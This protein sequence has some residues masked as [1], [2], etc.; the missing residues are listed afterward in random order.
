MAAL[1]QVGFQCAMPGGS[2]FL[3][4]PAPT[5]AGDRAFATAE[6][7]SQFLIREQSVCCVPWDDAGRNL[8]FAVTYQ[9]SD[10]A[11]EDALMS[12]TVRRLGGL[13]LRF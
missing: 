6:D 5:A 3:Y 8:R 13:G 1:R 4:T 2:Y 11:A 7:A 9:A 12:E 10:E